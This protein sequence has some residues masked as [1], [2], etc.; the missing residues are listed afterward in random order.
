MDSAKLGLVLRDLGGR[1]RDY[2]APVTTDA[3]PSLPLVCVPTTAGTGAEATRFAVATRVEFLGGRP[4]Q[5]DLLGKGRADP[6]ACAGPISP[7]GAAIG[8]EGTRE[9]RR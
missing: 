6:D 8:I 7:K 9:S 3:A 2:K 1:C 5:E 4:A